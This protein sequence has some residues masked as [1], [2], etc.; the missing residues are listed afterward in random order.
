MAY[1]KPFF[2]NNIPACFRRCLLRLGQLA[3]MAWL[4][5]NVSPASAQEK[6]ATPA[7]SDTGTNNT[8]ADKAW[9]EVK[10]AAQQPMPPAEWQSQKPTREQVAKFYIPA[11]KTG[12]DKAKDFYTRYPDHPKA[13]DARQLEYKLLTIAARQF[14]DSSQTARL[15]AIESERLKD[16]KLGNDERFHLRMAATARLIQDLP[17]KMDD[18]LKSVQALQKDFPN[19]D[20]VYQLLLMAVSQSEGDKAKALAQQIIDSPAPE[21]I[22]EQAKGLLNKMDALGKPVAIQYTAVD[23]RTVDVAKLKGKVVLVDFWATWCGPCVGELP[24]VKAAYSKLHDQGF[25][26]VGISFDQQKDK[27]TKFVAE[28]EMAWPQFFDGEGW[29]NKFGKEFGINSI[30]AMWL[31]DKKGN[32]RDLNGR[33]G[34]E[35]KVK[36]LLAE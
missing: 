31:V 22:K 15:E 13:G 7:A 8:E 20:E 30:P 26:I 25:E 27:L 16:P 2:M 5:L 18:F 24:H 28:N 32:L 36:K 10:K 34:L 1:I 9:K 19:R 6:P 11:L 21:Q 23:G 29:G 33:D 4:V 3:M 14:G 35:D 12:A 17:D